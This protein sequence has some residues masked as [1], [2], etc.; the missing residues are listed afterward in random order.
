MRRILFLRYLLFLHIFCTSEKAFSGTDNRYLYAV[1]MEALVADISGV[2]WYDQNING[3]IDA[4]EFSLPN[5]PV[6]LFTCNGQFVNATISQANGTY[7]FNDVPKGSYKIY[8]SLA[9]TGN[10]FSFTI[11]NETTDN[12]VNDSGYSE[13]IIAN[14]DNF[15]LNAGIT[16][17]PVVGDKV[18]EDL[19]GDGI[20]DFG[21]PGIENVVVEAFSDETLVASTTT[22]NNGNYFFNTLL[23]GNYVFRFLASEEY[24]PT[25]HIPFH[26]SNS[27]ITND[28][29]PFTTAGFEIQTTSDGSIDA[30]F[31]RCAKIC[32]T[33]YNDV[34]ESDSLDV[35]ENGITGVRVNLWQVVDGDTLFYGLTTTGLKPE[36]PSTDG[37]YEFCVPPGTY[38]V[39]IDRSDLPEYLPG[40][41]LATDNPETFN[42]FFEYDDIL[43]TYEITVES[44]DSYCNINQ[45]FYCTG[46][47]TSRVWLDSNQNGLQDVSESGLENIEV[48][49][50]NAS[51]NIVRVGSTDE[52]GIV[53][54]KTVRKGSY[55]L[56]YTIGNTYIFTSPYQGP[57]LIDSDVNG[58]YGDGTTPLFNLISCNELS[59]IDA[60]VSLKP[61]PLTWLNVSAENITK[62]VNKI[63]WEVAKEVNVSHYQVQKSMDG[64]SWNDINKVSAKGNETDFTQYTYLDKQA[65]EQNI[66]YRLQS[67]DFDGA[68]SYSEIVYV[69]SKNQ[70][71]HITATPNPATNIVEISVS[72]VNENEPLVITLVNQMGQK[73]VEISQ[74]ASLSTVS[75]EQIPDGIYYIHVKSGNG[76]NYTQKLVVKK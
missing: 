9:N 45:G 48:T 67:N 23:P 62:G 54:F 25:L 46:E 34:N 28:N 40:A 21:E 7:S 36:T 42:H 75:L 8:A 12:H 20:Q 15:V 30:G 57:V 17:F 11:Q 41:P 16:I 5:I 76:Q 27:K 3:M 50:R 68:I 56:Q 43:A 59:G 39:E 38:F 64:I 66:Y 24:K 44:N 47:I 73:V 70:K 63:L 13:C 4:S 69:R 58:F 53:N 32:G 55:Y 72:D 33:I 14:D 35:F 22:N 52:F 10:L 31:Y 65:D 49:L 29:G 2:V 74:A 18:W 60:G 71:N 1:N 26:P 61:L 37:Y 6:L 51:G 19:D